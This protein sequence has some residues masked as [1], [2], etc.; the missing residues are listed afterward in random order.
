VQQL[1]TVVATDGTIDVNIFA[2]ATAD[3]QAKK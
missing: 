2:T 3:K 1:A